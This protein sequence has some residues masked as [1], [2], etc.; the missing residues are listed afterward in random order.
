[1]ASNS[2]ITVTG[3]DFDSIRLNLRNFI[4]GR[5]EFSDFDFE[6]SAIGTLLDLLAYNTY[7]MSF[8]AN[9]AANESFLDTAQ[10]YDNVVSRAKMLGYI[11]TSVRGPTA[12][13][14]I[15]FTTP[16][17]ST[18]RSINI[19][20]DTK[21]R[22]SV[23][24]VSYS[25]V[26]PKSYV[27]YANTSNGF[28]G[29]INITEGIPLIH[30][31]LFTAAN[32]SFVLPNANTDTSSI[33]VS[34]TTA[35]NTQTYV[36]ATDL[37]TV[38]STSKVFFV[39]PDRNKLYKVLFG[40][41]IIG[42]KP[43]FNSTVTISY[44]VSNGSRAN[45]ANNF[46]AVSTVG[47]QSSFTL[48]VVDRASGGA[49]IESIESI[50]YNAPR[51][52]E[53]QNRA[54]TLEDYRRLIL[55]DNPDLSAVSLWGGEDNVPPIYGK[56]Y[57][58][59]K[60]KVG[61]LIS[62]NRKQSIITNIRK[63]SVQSIDL[64]L[65]DPTYLYIIPIIN[66]RYDP[67][68]TTLD[69]SQLATAVAAKVVSY[70]SSNLNRFEGKF[71]YSRFLDTVDSSSRA[72]VTSTAKISAR[73]RFVPS[74][75]SRNTYTLTFNRKINYP[76]AGYVS[77]TS[78]SAFTLDGARAFFDDNGFGTLRIYKL[79]DGNKVFLRTNAGTINYDTGVLSINS[80]LPDDVST[81]ELSIT[82]ELD[83]YNVSPVRNQ[84]VLIAGA[85]VTVINDNT[86]ATEAILDTINTLG[87]T[88]TLS[89]TALTVTTF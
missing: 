35:G 85:T 22:A 52:Y 46:T 40:D 72:I 20:K 16:A 13:L 84:I 79:V 42:T 28:K 31:Y 26:T 18:F 14:L 59:I 58:A 41:G 68:E 27:I 83:E 47:D 62:T 6:D 56:V 38:N 57:G 64:E 63:Y 82:V 48:S 73:K 60:P 25:F 88:L 9:M 2:A 7:Y 86:G 23:N 37:L 21:F 4:A 5:S 12:N 54:V 76:S 70:E 8:Y 50:R 45:G 81:N 51:L 24:G 74:L 69:A 89:S 44:R 34:V 32:T 10:I 30:R 67:I 49:E 61:T 15:S 75:I 87:N 1:M 80:F 78:S 71:R 19:D 39:E 55:R 77:A 66:V 3:L 33:F 36:E 11:P 17:N 43:S 53:T 65:V 29:H